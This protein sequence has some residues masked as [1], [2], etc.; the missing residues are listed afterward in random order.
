MRI[1]RPYIALLVSGWRG[2]TADGKA[3][4]GASYQAVF[5]VAITDFI[6][7]HGVPNV[8]LTGGA[9]GA[10]ALAETWAKRNALP[11]EVRKADWKTHGEAAGPLRNTEL[12][13]AC[14]HVLA[15]PH[16]T[17]S[18]GTRDAMRKATAAGRQMVVVELDAQ[19]Q[20]EEWKQGPLSVSD[21][22]ESVMKNP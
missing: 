22:A 7:V 20:E 21:Y 3:A 14:T 17:K 8:V 15:F 16:A 6:L 4:S 9:R 1:M 5:D 18:R 10:D 11:L 12:V 13:A 19:Q 2:M